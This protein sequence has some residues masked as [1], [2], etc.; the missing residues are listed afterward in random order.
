MAAALSAVGQK[1][2]YST[3]GGELIFSFAD[4]TVNGV[5]ATTTFRFSP[6]FNVQ[7][8]VHHDLTEKFGILTGFNIRNVGFIFDPGTYYKTRNYTV[9][10][11]LG[12]KLG[13]ME[14]KYLFT[15]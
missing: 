11:P 15:G 6:F 9:G 4:A 8:Q 2:T 14:G 12:I 10:L 7:T 3:T 5:N 13:N 1:K